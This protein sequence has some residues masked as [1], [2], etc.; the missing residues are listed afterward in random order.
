MASCY[1]LETRREFSGLILHFTNDVRWI[2]CRVIGFVRMTYEAH[3]PVMADHYV[4]RVLV[5]HWRLNK[6]NLSHKL[7]FIKVMQ[8]V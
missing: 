4:T 5:T 3:S 2:H 6:L 7:Y 8:C 1:V